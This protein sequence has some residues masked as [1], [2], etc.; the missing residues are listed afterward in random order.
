MEQKIVFASVEALNT[1]AGPG[2][3]A[4][5]VAHSRLDNR[6]TRTYATHKILIG[7]LLLVALLTMSDLAKRDN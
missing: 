7:I 4:P 1:P 5:E 2:D 3:Y 6:F